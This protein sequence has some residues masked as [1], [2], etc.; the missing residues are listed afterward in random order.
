MAAEEKEGPPSP[1]T[2]DRDVPELRDYLRPGMKVLD[3]GCGPGTITVGVAKA[4]EPGQ[5]IGIDPSEREISTARDWAARA[6]VDGSLSFS[7]GDAHELDFPDATFDVVYSHTVT[8][9]LL[10]P[11]RAL[12]EQ[13]RVAK[14]GGWV[15]ASGVRDPGILNRYPACPNWDAAWRALSRYYDS[16]QEGMR[17]KGEAPTAYHDRETEQLPS[18]LF[19]WDMHAA[20]KCPGWFRE[21]GLSNLEVRIKGDMVKFNVIFRGPEL[22]HREIGQRQLEKFIEGCSEI[23]EVYQAPRMEGRRMTMVLVPK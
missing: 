22:R 19:F 7:V 3:V 4:V 20:R 13:K 8:H 17:A 16:M 14:P 2:L 12:R 21:A 10:D 23:A 18:Y 15:V 11:V 1:R 5:V 9:F 6:P